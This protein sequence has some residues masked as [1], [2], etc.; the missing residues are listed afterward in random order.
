MSDKCDKRPCILKVVFEGE[1]IVMVYS[2]Q[3]RT[4]PLVYS[5]S[6]QAQMTKIEVIAQLGAAYT[7]GAVDADTVLGTLDI[8][9]VYTDVSPIK[10]SDVQ[11]VDQAQHFLSKFV[12][13]P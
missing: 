5:C 6:C 4:K 7:T 3:A 8:R 9:V 13:K 11:N 1:D 2:D 12:G 10:D